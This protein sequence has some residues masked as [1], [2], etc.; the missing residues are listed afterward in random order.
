M[1]QYHEAR[2]AYE[3]YRAKSEGKSLV[4][5]APIPPFDDLPEAIKGAWR[6]AAL[7]LLGSSDPPCAGCGTSMV[8]NGQTY[9]CPNCGERSGQ[10]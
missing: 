7:A 10:S 3:G 2:I 6:A 1:D 4:S 8:R 9:L 5:G